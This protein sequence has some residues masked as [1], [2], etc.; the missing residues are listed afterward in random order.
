VTREP[1]W[2]YALCAVVIGKGRAIYIALLCSLPLGRPYDWLS[3]VR[4][5]CSMGSLSAFRHI[6]AGTQRSLPCV[7]FRTAG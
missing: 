4:W 6:P 3:S 7:S 5:T 1:R 2:I